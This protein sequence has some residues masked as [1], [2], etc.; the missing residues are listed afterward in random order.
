MAISVGTRE[1]PCKTP[2]LEEGE[3]VPI[4]VPPPCQGRGSDRSR[5][6]GT[7][8]ELHDPAEIIQVNPNEGWLPVAFQRDI[9]F[10]LDEEGTIIAR[11][12]LPG[13]DAPL[14][15]ECAPSS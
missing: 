9:P 1:E 2:E 12:E 5:W 10:G 4:P 3:V 8:E 14:E 6:E 7:D 15:Y 11:N 13:Y